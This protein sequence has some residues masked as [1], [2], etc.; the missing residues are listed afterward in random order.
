MTAPE[1]G[2]DVAALRRR[3][4][5]D[6]RTSCRSSDPKGPDNSDPDSCMEA[7][8]S[9]PSNLVASCR[10]SDAV[11]RKD[12]I[13]AA[14]LVRPDG[15]SFGCCLWESSDAAAAASRNSTETGFR[16]AA[17]AAAADACSASLDY[18]T[19]ATD[20]GI[21][22]AVWEGRAGLDKHFSKMI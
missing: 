16:P 1:D 14:C 4:V 17:A 15:T 22:A 5:A 20:L 12:G 8:Y 18:C 9:T 7:A 10:M 11:S 13:E 19:R 6:R 21:Q 2:E 3:T